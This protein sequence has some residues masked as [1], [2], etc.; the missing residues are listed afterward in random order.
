MVIG[1]FKRGFLAFVAPDGFVFQPG[2]V[3]AQPGLE[4]LP[5]D[6]SDGPVLNWWPDF[7]GAAL[8]ADLGFTSGGATVNARYFTVWQRQPDGRWRWIYDGG[9]PLA[10]PLPVEPNGPVVLLPRATAAAGSADRALI[11]IEAIENR[12][13]REARSDAAAARRLFLSEDALVAG[14]REASFPGR[15]GIDAEL[16]RQPRIQLWYRLG[17]VASR[18]GDLAFT[19]GQ[20]RW[21]EGARWGHYARIW[22]ARTEGWRLVADFLIPAPGTPPADLLQEP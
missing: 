2:P 7:A 19:W 5:D 3:A 1:F 12:L 17:G 6:A 8:S 15:S 21:N 13:A 18:A 22:Q 10:A 4:A 14:S 9:P 11:Q 20:A 16:E